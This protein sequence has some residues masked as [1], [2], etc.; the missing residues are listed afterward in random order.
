MPRI[1]KSFV[2][3]LP[4]PKGAPIFAWDDRV[5][6]FGVKVLPS[7]KRK[8]ILKYRTQGGR[9]GRQRWLGLGLHGSVTADQARALAQ[10]ALASIAEGGD[11]QA[12]RREAATLPTLADVWQRYERDHLGLRK[13]STQRN[14]RAIWDDRL[15][16]AFGKHAVREI[17]RGAI[18]AFHKKLS[19]TPYQANRTLA[20]LSKLMNLAGAWEWREGTN[21]CRHI[22]KFQE[23]PRQRFLSVD[24]I[25]SVQEA[26][27]KLLIQGKI[28]V[29]AAS[30]LEL[31]LL[32]GARSGELTGA[33]W[34]WV[35]WDRQI[36][37]LPDS[38]TGAKTIY[39]SKAA[40]GVLREQHA[41][42]HFQPYIFPGRLAGKHIH[43]LRKPWALICKEAGLD[44][45]RVHDLRHTSAS[46][47][48]GSGVSLAIVGRLLGHTQAQTTL[49][50]AHLDADPALQAADAI[51]QIVQRGRASNR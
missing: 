48:L 17:G 6:G 5:S 34:D 36:I 50:Y 2:E 25:S 23:R 42:S 20:L 40:M 24:E 44:G 10:R 22:S 11:P 4:L 1:T 31:L 15:G 33:Q 45:V 29:H 46:L 12:G 38:K 30:I 3:S 32:T 47:A 49:R 28:T 13:A 18:D 27:A 35:D 8:Y 16:P 41:R 19:A 43:N 21:P 14:Y 26:T 51:G 9:A 37:S 7:G 39:L